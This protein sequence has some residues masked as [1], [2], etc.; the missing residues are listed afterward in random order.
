MLFVNAQYEAPIITKLIEM[1]NPQPPNLIQVENTTALGIFN[2]AIKKICLKQ[3]ICGSIGFG[4][5]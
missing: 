5:E 3:W 4:A 1:N 2:E